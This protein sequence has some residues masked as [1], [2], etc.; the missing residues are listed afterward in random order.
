MNKERL[1]ALETCLFRRNGDGEWEPG[2]MLNDGHV[3]ILDQYGSFVDEC[4]EVKRVP[5]IN[6]VLDVFLSEEYCNRFVTSRT[7]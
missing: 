6:L 1:Y 7:K 5:G 3:G 2:I 4:W